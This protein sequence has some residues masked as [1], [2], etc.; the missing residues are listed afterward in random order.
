MQWL[1]VGPI[2]DV[3]EVIHP[4]SS[5]AGN[6]SYQ[7]SDNFNP[8]NYPWPHPS[9]P[10]SNNSHVQFN[11]HNQAF[12]TENL[13]SMNFGGGYQGY[14]GMSTPGNYYGNYQHPL[15]VPSAYQDLQQAQHARNLAIRTQS[16]SS[17]NPYYGAYPES[18]LRAHDNLNALSSLSNSVHQN[19][20]Q[21]HGF[22][23]LNNDMMQ[24]PGQYWQQQSLHG[25]PYPNINS[26]P[27]N[28]VSSA[29][30]DSHGG[31]SN[32]QDLENS[33]FGSS[34]YNPRDGPGGDERSSN[35]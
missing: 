24:M 6:S 11:H 13:A 9:A 17:N 26:D 29:N 19:P 21:D 31:A 27:G 7:N 23:S 10:I 32:A 33:M 15:M 22:S 12:V 16:L 30:L 4:H 28:F 2:T 14:G 18:D 25:S 8:S 3:D 34:R 20:Y 5:T 35:R 1:G